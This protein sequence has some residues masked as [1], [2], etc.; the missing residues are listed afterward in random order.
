[1]KHSRTG[2][3]LL[4]VWLLTLACAAP[5]TLSSG[6]GREAREAWTESD[7]LERRPPG[8]SRGPPPREPSRPG[9]GGKRRN[10]NPRESVFNAEPTPEQREAARRRSENAALETTLRAQYWRLKAEAERLYPDKVGRFEEHHFWP[11][12]L[13]GPN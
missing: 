5:E 6:A 13:G 9:R 10:R 12:Y 8:P 7:V 11:R 3:A 4:A 2:V 1:M